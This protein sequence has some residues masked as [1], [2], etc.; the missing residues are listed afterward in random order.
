MEGRGDV[1]LE[2]VEIRDDVK[3]GPT[4]GECGV[5]VDAICTGCKTERVKRVSADEIDTDSETGTFRH[6]CH[7]CRKG[8]WFN[9]IAVRWDLIE[10][11]G[12]DLVDE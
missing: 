4:A 2:A 12:G 10:T 9:V 11:G 3:L 5:P 8:C 7:G 6:V 1:D